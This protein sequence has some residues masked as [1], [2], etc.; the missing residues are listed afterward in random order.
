LL[1]A[2]EQAAFDRLSVFAADFDLAAATAVASDPADGSDILDVLGALVDKSM[3]TVSISEH[4]ARYRLLETLR[5]Y[6]EERLSGRAETAA[7]QS[8]HLA[9]YVR[10]A[11]QT[12]S[13][14]NSPRGIEATQRFR[15]EWPNLRAAVTTAV[16]RGDADSAQ[17]IMD[18]TFGFALV[19]LRFEHGEWAEAVIQLSEHGVNVSPAAYGYAASFAWRAGEFDRAMRL[20][21]SGIAAAP[22]PEHPST[23]VCWAYYVI[24]AV[25]N[26]MLNEGVAGAEQLGAVVAASNPVPIHE[27]GA[28]SA[29]LMLAA[30]VDHA[31]IAQHVERMEAVA[32]EVGSPPLSA[33]ASMAE[34]IGYEFLDDPDRRLRAYERCAELAEKTQ[35]RHI[36][37]SALS[38]MASMAADSEP[39][40]ALRL[41]YEALSR[42]YDDRFW[43]AIWVAILTTASCLAAI[44]DEA[45]ARTVVGHLEAHHRGVLQGFR[46]RGGAWIQR[47]PDTGTDDGAR[48]DRHTLVLH[49]LSR[50]AD[51]LG[52]QDAEGHDA[53]SRSGPSGEHDSAMPA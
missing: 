18:E 39:E 31:S 15:R 19:D 46:A 8:R 28:C 12:G 41:C 49:T 24:A 29:F 51:H 23:L 44:D 9:H 30:A 22:A 37:A 1:T 32:N 36:V 43:P 3:L 17:A 48:M 50:L 25:T 52:R 47:L 27:F 42:S 38:G 13:L 26:G 10:L 35:A 5:Q 6:G 45:G 34:G 40:S 11:E 14:W 53:A 4:T 7:A 21:T 16:A 2:T 33:I 20:A